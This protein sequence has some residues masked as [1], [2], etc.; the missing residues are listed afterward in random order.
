MD[1]DRLF[2]ILFEKIEISVNDYPLETTWSCDN[3]GGVHSE[4]NLGEPL[5]KKDMAEKCKSDRIFEQ[6]CGE[7]RSRNDPIEN[8]CPPARLLSSR[9]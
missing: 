9:K 5:T 2:S 3:C 1:N 4:Y 6:L 7:V 8:M